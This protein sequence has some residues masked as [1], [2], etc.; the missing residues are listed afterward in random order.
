MKTKSQIFDFD[1]FVNCLKRDLTLNG[2]SWLLKALMMLGVTTILL[3]L[4]T[5]VTLDSEPSFVVFRFCGTV[6]CA[7]GASLFME[8][9]TSNG[10]RL[11]TLMSPASTLEKFLSRWVICVFGTTIAFLI[12][13]ALADLLRVGFYNIYY[14]NV[15][16]G[17]Y[18]DNIRYLGPIEMMKQTEHWYYLWGS[19]ATVQAIFVLGS[20]VAP[21]N[22]FLKTFGTLL[23]FMVIFVCVIGYVYTVLGPKGGYIV[24]NTSEKL[25]DTLPKIVPICVTVFCY[26]TAYFRMKESEIINRL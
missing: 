9:M 16:D 22:A 4:S 5:G 2:R 20:T 21:K 11:N 17:H 12:C 10:L 1:R 23:V 6:F 24:D 26:I 7:L 19:I 3:V 25:L 15:F 13:F 18:L 14:H 8:N